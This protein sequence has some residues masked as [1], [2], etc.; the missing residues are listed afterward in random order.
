MRRFQVKQLL[1]ASSSA[2]YGNRPGINLGEDQ[3]PI[4]PVSY[5]GASK[6]ASEAMISAYCHMNNM[7]SWILRFSNVVGERLTHGVVYDFIKKLQ[8]NPRQL[9]I[10]GDGKQTKPYLYIDD[11]LKAIFLVWHRTN[12]NVNY[13]NIGVETCTSV[14]RIADIICDEM[15]LSGVK[16]VYTGSKEGWPGDVASFKYDLSKICKLGWYPR[17]N[18]DDAIRYTVRRIIS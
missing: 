14:K 15:G 12:Q 13:Y 9:Y 2:V 8:H 1:F 11:L 3:G 7:K 17:F 10:L 18:S 4:L 16:Y 6:A 5:Y